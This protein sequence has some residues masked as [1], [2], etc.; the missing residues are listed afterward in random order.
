MDYQEKKETDPT[1][2]TEPN[3]RPA[4]VTNPESYAVTLTGEILPAS[5]YDFRA[6]HILV[7]PPGA[8]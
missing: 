5:Q 1:R 7:E 3:R 6:H 8:T 4:G 2:S